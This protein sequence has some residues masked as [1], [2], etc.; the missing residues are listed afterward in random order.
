MQDEVP[1]P[2]NTAQSLASWKRTSLFQLP[3][4]YMKEAQVEAGYFVGFVWSF[5]AMAC[6]LLTSTLLEV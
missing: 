4:W 5:E 2:F 6:R 3:A 1:V